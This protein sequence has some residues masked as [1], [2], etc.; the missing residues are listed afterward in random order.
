[1]DQSFNSTLLSHLGNCASSLH[2]YL[3]IGS[4]FLAYK[5]I[6]STNQPMN[7]TNKRSHR[8][9][10]SFPIQLMTI[11]EYWHTCLTDSSSRNSNGWHVFLPNLLTIKRPRVPFAPNTVTTNPLNDDLP[12]V[13]RLI[14]LNTLFTKNK[15]QILILIIQSNVILGLRGLAKM[16]KNPNINSINKAPIRQLK[17]LS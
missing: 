3:I 17:K 4:T 5:I 6:F 7:V 16:Q 10:N 11:L 13:P 8:V 1:M 2:M 14:L 15:D 12:P 9:S